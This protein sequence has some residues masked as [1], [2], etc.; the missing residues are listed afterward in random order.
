MVKITFKSP[1]Q[2]QPFTLEIDPN[3]IGS[4]LNLKKRVG[5]HTGDPAENIKLIH[6]GKYNKN[7]GKILK[8]DV[9]VNTLGLAEEDTMHAVIKKEN[10]ST[11]AKT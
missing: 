7:V 6:K 1:T 4:V 5:Q 2:S 8:D 10:S 9:G 3:S 11:E